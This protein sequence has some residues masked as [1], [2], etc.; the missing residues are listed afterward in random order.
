MISNYGMFQDG[1]FELSD[2]S[3]FWLTYRQS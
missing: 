1:I 3:N 2:L